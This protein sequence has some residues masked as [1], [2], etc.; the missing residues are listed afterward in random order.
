[1]LF[2]QKNEKLVKLSKIITQQLTLLE[3]LNI[4]D[5]ESV[6]IEHPKTSHKLPKTIQ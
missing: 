2:K 5:S 4:T 3:I 1:M 6:T